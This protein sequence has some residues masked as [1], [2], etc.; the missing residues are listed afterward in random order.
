[1]YYYAELDDRDICVG[2]FESLEI[3]EDTA[4][5]EI[6]SLDDYYIGLQYD[7]TTGQWEEASS[8]AHSTDNISYGGERLTD[9]LNNRLFTVNIL[10]DSTI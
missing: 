2:V 9:V 3:I 4:Y 7:R 10:G 1:M 5:I 6:G 8:F